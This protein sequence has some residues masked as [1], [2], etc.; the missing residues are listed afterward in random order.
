MHPVSQGMAAPARATGFIQSQDESMSHCTQTG[1]R[2]S[3]GGTHRLGRKTPKAG[4]VQQIQKRKN[5]RRN[6]KV[7]PEVCRTSSGAWNIPALPTP[8]HGTA[9]DGLLVQ[10]VPSA[11]SSGVGTFEL[12]G[13]GCFDRQ[14]LAGHRSISSPRA[15]PP[16]A[17]CYIHPQQPLT[18]PQIPS[19]IQAATPGEEPAKRP[20]PGSPAP[21]C[22]HI[23]IP[24][25]TDEIPAIPRCRMGRQEGTGSLQS[26]NGSW[27]THRAGLPPLTHIPH[28]KGIKHGSK[29]LKD[30]RICG[31]SQKLKR[32]KI[33]G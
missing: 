3:T 6:T 20:P 31:K 5:M 18:N 23:H 10:N 13:N 25:D 15:R 4:S 27:G 33:P 9:L 29:A 32:K 19:S 17:S 2:Q 30:L 21:P 22:P 24:G 16:Q 12:H 11:S 28:Y 7:V 14:V 26:Q 8:L 1:M